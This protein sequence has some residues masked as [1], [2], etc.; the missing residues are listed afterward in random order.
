MRDER[1][2]GRRHRVIAQLLGAR[3]FERLAFE[4]RMSLTAAR[5]DDQ[6]TSEGS[7]RVAESELAGLGLPAPRRLTA[8]AN[9]LVVADTFGFHARGRSSRPACRV[10]VWAYGRRNPF[11]PWIGLDLLRRTGLDSLR[12]QV[13]WRFRDFLDARHLAPTKWKPRPNSGAYDP[14]RPQS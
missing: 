5:S 10:E 11:L 12:A 6:M 7:F 1:L 4:R 14:W 13:F 3:P 2:V 9:T 8:R